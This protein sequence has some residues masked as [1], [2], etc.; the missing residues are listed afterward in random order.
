MYTVPRYGCGRGRSNLQPARLPAWIPC[1][2]SWAATGVCP[3]FLSFIT[4]Q[5]H[6]IVG[7]KFAFIIRGP[8]IMTVPSSNHLKHQLPVQ[9]SFMPTHQTFQTKWRILMWDESQDHKQF[10][11]QT[12]RKLMLNESTHKAENF[13]FLSWDGIDCYIKTSEGTLPWSNF[14]AVRQCWHLNLP[15][16]SE[17]CSKAH[18]DAWVVGRDTL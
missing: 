1:R 3:P 14:T 18:C 5:S 17:F 2:T 7:E 16:C 8:I 13:H 11:P 12:E 10:G 9:L 15:L 6:K 4:Q